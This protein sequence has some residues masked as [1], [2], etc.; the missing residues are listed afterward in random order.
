M[1]ILLYAKHWQIFT[2]AFL[3]PV[4]LIMGYFFYF[5]DIYNAI[6]SP[7]IFYIMP[8]AIVILLTVIYAWLWTAGLTFSRNIEGQ[9][10]SPN[11]F[12]TLIIIPVILLV[13]ILIL[14][15]S[16][17]LGFIIMFYIIPALVVITPL[18][19]VFIIS[20]IY[21]YYFVARSIKEY[22]TRQNMKFEDFFKE[23]MLILFFPVGIWFLQPRINKMQR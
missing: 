14:T 3:V 20:I 6:Y 11:L 22:E 10:R 12:K 23:F 16:G 9:N 13:L 5:G 4:L 21:C 2:F 17:R 1:K 19:F 8:C 7:S 18:L 15:I